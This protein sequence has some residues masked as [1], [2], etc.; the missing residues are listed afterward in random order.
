MP[1]AHWKLKPKDCD[2]VNDMAT[3]VHL[4]CRDKGWYTDLKTLQP[5]DRNIPEMLALMHSEI[6]EMLEAHRKDLM[7]SHIKHRKGIEVEA[8]DLFIRLLDFCGY[9]G[10]DLGRATYEK[11]DYNQMREDHKIENRQKPGGKT[12]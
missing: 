10:L 2:A 5:I 6:S 1:R 12:I 11:F 9:L 8:A 3:T 7:D 4:S